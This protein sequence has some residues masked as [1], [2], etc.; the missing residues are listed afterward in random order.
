MQREENVQQLMEQCEK[1]GLRF[2]FD[3]GLVFVRRPQSGDRGQQNALLDGLGRYIPDIYA[4]TKARAIGLAAR[5]F[6]GQTLITKDSGAGRLVGAEEDG[7]L[8]VSVSKEMRKVHEQEIRNAQI[9][10]GYDAANLFII[11]D[12]AEETAD[13]ASRIGEPEP[14]G[15]FFDRLRGSSRKG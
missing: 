2:E 7:H 6:I 1:L 13:A 4:L 3:R 14:R 9:T 12:A 5:D 11:L 10:M 15:G 8:T